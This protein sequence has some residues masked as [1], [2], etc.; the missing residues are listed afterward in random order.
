MKYNVMLESD[1][2]ALLEMPHQYIVVR[3]LNRTAPEG[4]QWAHGIYFTHA[5]MGEE[6]KL[7][8]FFNA[9]NVYLKKVNPD[10]VTYEKMKE[11]AFGLKDALVGNTTEEE[12][13]DFCKINLGMTKE[14]L[15]LFQLDPNLANNW[16]D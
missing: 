16:W 14:E 13:V 6:E 9:V 15:E 10:F 2:Y 12:T 3:G 1:N 8:A 11:F 7:E 5:N 4:Q